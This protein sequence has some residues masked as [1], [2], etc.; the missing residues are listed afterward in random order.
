MDFGALPNIVKAIDSHN[1][2]YMFSFEFADTGSQKLA[3]SHNATYMFFFELAD[4]GPKK[5]DFILLCKFEGM[6]SC[7]QVG[8]KPLT[9]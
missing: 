9:D 5:L 3:N 4:T 7:L 8:Y 6:S 2:S 1:A